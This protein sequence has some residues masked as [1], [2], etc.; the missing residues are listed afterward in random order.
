MQGIVVIEE[1]AQG[2]EGIDAHAWRWSLSRLRA[3]QGIKHP[4]GEGK[5]DPIGELDH[6]TL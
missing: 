4:R 2:H 5:L 6:D 3:R 1:R